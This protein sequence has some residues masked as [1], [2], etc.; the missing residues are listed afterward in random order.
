MGVMPTRKE[1]KVMGLT[2]D[3]HEVESLSVALTD[4]EGK[5]SE[6]AIAG[7]RARSRA[8]R[9][10]RYI[11]ARGVAY[12]GT[13][14]GERRQKTVNADALEGYGDFLKAAE[15]ASVLGVSS[16]MVTRLAERDEIPAIRIGRAWRFPRER[17]R[18]YLERSHR[19]AQTSLAARISRRARRTRRTSSPQTTTPV[20]I[21]HHRP[22]VVEGRPQPTRLRSAARTARA[23]PA[24]RTVSDTHG[25]A[26]RSG[27]VSRR[28]SGQP[29]TAP[30]RAASPGRP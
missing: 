22:L 6:H 25:P 5:T 2:I 30:R 8:C 24:L 10:A 21:P 7:K 3:G 27:C 16:R 18:E 28:G 17:L 15:V 23:R 9:R 4:A 13:S 20:A 1:D 12:D 14:T 11:H 19:V 26:R 29:A